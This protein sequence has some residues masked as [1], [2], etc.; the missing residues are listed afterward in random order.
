VLQGFAVHGDRPAGSKV[1]R[2]E[3]LA[4]QVEAGHVHMIIGDWNREVLDEMQMFPMGPHD[5]R[6]DSIVGAYN[7]AA[8]IAATGHLGMVKLT[9]L[10]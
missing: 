9:G 6:T 10:Y 2:A 8:E 7:A 3:P 1:T 5:D 4:A